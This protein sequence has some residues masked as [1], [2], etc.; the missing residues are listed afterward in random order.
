MISVVF[1]SA[2]CETDPAQGIVEAILLEQL[3]VVHDLVVIPT[4]GTLHDDS[5]SSHGPWIHQTLVTF[6]THVAREL[7]VLGSSR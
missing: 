7:E 4:L 3:Q 2:Q 1:R 6:A 5:A